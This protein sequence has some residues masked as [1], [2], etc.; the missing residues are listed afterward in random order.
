[1]TALQYFD[2]HDIVTCFLTPYWFM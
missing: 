1:M 2:M